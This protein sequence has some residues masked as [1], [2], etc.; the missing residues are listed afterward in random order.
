MYEFSKIGLIKIEMTDKKHL[1]LAK[2][3]KFY[4]KLNNT[5]I[6]GI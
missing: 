3:H 5:N 4:I 2:F 6:I 1:L